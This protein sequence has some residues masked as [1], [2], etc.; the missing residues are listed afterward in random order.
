MEIAFS[1]LPRALR[2]V[3]VDAAR[4]CL[5]LFK[6]MVPILIGVKILKELG[7][8]AY[9]AKPLAPLMS[10]V[11]LPPECG[12]TWATA[13]ANNLYAALAV[14][15]ALVPDMAPLTVA[16][17][18][19]IATMMLIAHNIFVEGAIAKRCGVGFW[20]QA[21]L[22]LGG[23]LAC[24][25]LLHVVFSALGLFTDPAP[26][27]F[28]PSAEDSG[29][30]TWAFG[31]IKNLGMIYCVIAALV[32][33]MRLLETLGVTRLF[34]AALL[35]FLRLMGIGGGAA[36]ITVIGLVMGLAYGSGLILH[37]VQKG[38]VAQR[39]VFSAIS[40]MSLSHALIED[41]LLM[42]L[43][44]ASLWGTFVGRLLFSLAVVAVLS[45]V[46]AGLARPRL[47]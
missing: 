10:L 18:T 23:A 22:R 37:D 6:V 46:A 17:S 33:I 9:L 21:V 43:I 32:G 45:R 26:L 7:W 12:L 5:D 4:I 31:E 13:I 2:A 35:P 40:L 8:I 14:H 29:L 36:T 20:G 15:A 39:D 19:V 28:T 30:W 47:A 24:G 34:E 1:A 42:Y 41:T 11:G 38:K 44:G 27:L 25:M 16:Q 3:A